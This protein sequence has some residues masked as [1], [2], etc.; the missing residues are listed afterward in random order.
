M[1]LRRTFALACALVL[2]AAGGSAANAQQKPSG[3]Y[4]RADL[5]GAYDPGNQISFP[6]TVT[7]GSTTFAI[8][9]NGSA[10]DDTSFIA[11][12]GA[13][14]RFS[15]MFRADITLS[16]TPSS[17]SA[18]ALTVANT[19]Q[20]FSVARN[21]LPVSVRSTAALLNGY[22]DIDGILP[23]RFDTVQPYVSAGV[24][25]SLNNTEAFFQNAINE[26]NFAVPAATHTSFAWSIGFGAGIPV[27]EDVMLDIGY[28]YLDLGTAKSG[29]A[30]GVNNAGNPTTAGPL[31]SKLT[32]H[33]I[34]AGFRVGF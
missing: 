9:A 15:P 6:Q 20:S 17:I 23:G 32:D 4:I 21:F 24:G 11:D 10:S 18:G 34:T 1:I 22:V 2:A 29:A 3:F 19:P 13:G 31:T 25:A 7:V 28:K 33:T 30:S 16:Y 27:G 12:L 5:G 14:Y 8:N 26:G